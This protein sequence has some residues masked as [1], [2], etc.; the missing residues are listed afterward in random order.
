MD[1]IVVT[2]VNIAI[3]FNAT[4]GIIIEPVMIP[5]VLDPTVNTDE[6]V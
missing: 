3:E 1:I 5:P 4:K 6:T 2:P